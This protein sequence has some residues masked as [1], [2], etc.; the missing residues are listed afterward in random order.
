MESIV[1]FTVYAFHG[2]AMRRAT[3]PK[4]RNVTPA[5]VQYP[6]SS[7]SSRASGNLS[8]NRASRKIY[9]GTVTIIRAAAD[10]ARPDG[11]EAFCAEWIV[12]RPFSVRPREILRRLSTGLDSRETSPEF[13]PKKRRATLHR[14]GVKPLFESGAI[15]RVSM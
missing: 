5:S 1:Y 4:R 3:K 8:L 12:S 6:R 11:C 13:F 7:S 10:A 15:E 9:L 2:D 14:R